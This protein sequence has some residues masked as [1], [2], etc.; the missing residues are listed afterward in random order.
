[1]AS[2]YYYL[3][4]K[5]PS[6]Y[7]FLVQTIKTY[8]GLANLNMKN[9]INSGLGSKNTPSC[10]TVKGRSHFISRLSRTVVVDS[11]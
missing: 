3:S 11:D 7:C 8:L 6:G 10:S 5:N 9:E 2:F 1:M 4:D